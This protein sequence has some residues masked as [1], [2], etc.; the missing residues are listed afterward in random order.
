MLVSYINEMKVQV[1]IGV[2][3]VDVP[4]ERK[5]TWENVSLPLPCGECKPSVSGV[6]EK[7]KTMWIFMSSLKC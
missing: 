6:K 4:T 2:N 7:L 3:W 1:R 5:A